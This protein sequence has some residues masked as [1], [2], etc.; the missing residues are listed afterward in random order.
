MLLRNSFTL[1]EWWYITGGSGNFAPSKLEI[2]A[3]NDSQL[4]DASN[5]TKDSML[6]VWV[7]EFLNS[8]LGV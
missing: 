6:D 4:P 1:L 2:F 5:F 8:Y 3:T 7:F